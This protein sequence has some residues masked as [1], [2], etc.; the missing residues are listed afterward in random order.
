MGRRKEAKFTT[1]YLQDGTGGTGAINEATPAVSDTSFGVD[2]LAMNDSV[3]IV[4]VGTRFTTAGIATVRT[5]TASNNSQ[6]W[7]VTIDATAGTF[8]LTLNGEETSAI[9]YNAVSSVVQTALEALASITAGDVTVTGDGPHTITMAGATFGNIA[10]NT[11]TSDPA[12]LT[13]GASTA[14]VA[15]VQDG[16]DTWD[17]TFTPAIA[18]GSV[19]V[20][21]AVITWLPQRVELV[22]NGDGDLAWTES[23]APIIDTSRGIIDG[24]R[25]GTEVPM[26]VNASMI[27]DWFVA[28][29]GGSITPYEALNKI[30]GAANWL[31]SAGNGVGASFCQPY[32]VDIVAVDA[33][34]CGSEQAEV[35]IFRSFMVEDVSPTLADATIE[36]SG[37]CVATRAEHTR[38]TNDA[39]AI[40]AIA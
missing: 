6:Q 7:T 27:M 1:L 30:N 37:V 5:V 34:N 8:T 32:A 12:L 2:T 16:T 4:Q 35:M 20:D 14:V 18:T 3:T 25:D 36:F 22:P 15:V 17:I 29:S 31:T 26:Q 19:P 38:V 9:A 40:G 10:T 11:L 24:A 28:S 39:D 21:D 33:P 23:K 13:G